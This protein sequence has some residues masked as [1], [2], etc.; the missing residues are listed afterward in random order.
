MKGYNEK[1]SFDDTEIAFRS[2]SDADLDRAYWLF[3]TLGSNFLTTAAPPL[4]NFA[5]KLCLPIEPLIKK[6][7]FKQFCGGETIAECE[8]VIAKLHRQ[9]T[10]AILDYAVEGV[11]QEGYFD[12]TAEEVIRII[13]RAK[14]DVRIPLA[15]FKPT[16][17]ARASLLEK[18]SSG[19]DL[20]PEESE[21][22]KRLEIRIDSICQAAFNAGVPVMIDAE[23]SWIQ[24]AI[25]LLVMKMMRRYN[26]ETAVI[27][28]TYQLYRIDMFEAL[29]RDINIAAREG[30]VLGAKLVRG[31]YMEKERIRAVEMGYLSPIHIT[32][33]DTD[34]DYNEALVWCVKNLEKVVIVAGT[35][36]EAS[37]RKLIEAMENARI[38]KDHRHIW[39]SQLLGMSD[40]LTF[41]LAG[42][43]FNVVKYVPYGPVK[44][45]LPYLFR[46]AEENTAIAGQTGRELTLIQKEK[47]RRRKEQDG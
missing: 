43:G 23:E 4:I 6:T 26:R 20:S 9:M 19:G 35:H 8:E 7:V 34:S 40:N 31:A 22:F 21:E 37:C 29:K 2:K 47:E 18:I 12:A 13:Q 41:N 28:N 30:F 5:F 36:N 14:D 44:K 32:K 42:A 11:E 3:R 16:G 46:R 10:R 1:L 45:V 27:C 38:S 39:F 15:V 17:V 33:E 25:D 24:D